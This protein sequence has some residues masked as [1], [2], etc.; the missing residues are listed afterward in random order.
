MLRRRGLDAGAKVEKEGTG[1]GAG[2]M[3]NNMVLV[4]RQ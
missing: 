1:G 2:R 3:K 4:L